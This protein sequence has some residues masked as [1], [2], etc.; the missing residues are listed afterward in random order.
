MDLV[1]DNKI[2][3]V[4]RLREYN[5][6]ISEFTSKFNDIPELYKTYPTFYIDYTELENNQFNNCLPISLN[7]IIYVT[8]TLSFKELLMNLID[9]RTDYIYKYM[10]PIIEKFIYH[11]KNSMIFN[12]PVD[13]IALLLT[14]YYDKIKYPMDLGTIRNNLHNGYYKDINSIFFDIMKTFDNAMIY[15]HTQHYVHQIAKTLLTEFNIDKNSIIDKINRELDKKSNHH[16]CKYCHIPESSCQLCGAKC[17]KLEPPTLICYGTCNQRIKRN[18]V[19]YVTID[20]I[21]SWCLRC[22]SALPH[23]VIENKP[24]KISLFKNN[25]LKR[26][27]DE[28]INESWIKC[29][30]CNQWVHQVCALYNDLAKLEQLNLTNKHDNIS[31][32]CPF[33]ILDKA[34]SINK[35]KLSNNKRKISELKPDSKQKIVK[36]NTGVNNDIR[37]YFFKKKNDKVKINEDNIIIEQSNI[38]TNIVSN[39]D[40]QKLKF[41]DKDNIK[42]AKDQ[43][44]AKSLPRTKLSDFLEKIIGD[45]LNELGFDNVMETVTIRLTSNTSQ[46][47]E[48][49][50]HVILNLMTKD[51]NSVP[52]FLPY[53]QKCILMFQSIN[54][55]DVCLFC[56]YVQEFDKNCPPPN[57]SVVYISYLDS[58][59]YFRPMEA[60][61]IVY[62]EILIG[63]L[64]WIQMRG[65]KQAHIWSCPPQRGDNFI[66]W[67][68]PTQ[69]KTPSRDRL[70]GWYKSMLFR[71]SLLGII[72][73][74]STLWDVYFAKYEKQEKKE[75]LIRQQRSTSISPSSTEKIKNNKINSNNSINNKPE[76]V[77]K[78]TKFYKMQHSQ[79]NYI[80]KQDTESS[81]N[82]P[83]IQNDLVPISPPIFEGDYWVNECLR[84]TKLY[85]NRDQ[86]LIE[87][88]GSNLAKNQKKVREILKIMLLNPLLKDFRN[89]VDIVL[90][91]IPNYFEII[92]KPMDINT[93]RSKLNNNSY[94]T[95]CDFAND[96][97]LIFNNSITFNSPTHILHELSRKE[98]EKFEKMLYLIIQEF[99]GFDVIANT[100]SL[101][102]NFLQSYPLY[103]Q[104]YNISPSMETNSSSLLIEE[105]F[106]N[107]NNIGKSLDNDF[108]DD[109]LD[110]CNEELD[111]NNNSITEIDNENEDDEDDVDISILPN[112]QRVT[113]NASTIS[114]ISTSS[115]NIW[116][117]RP[118]RSLSCGVLPIN[119]DNTNEHTILEYNSNQNQFNN[120][121]KGKEFIPD[122]INIPFKNPELG[123][124]G[125]FSM[126]NDL[127]KGVNHLKDDLFVITFANPNDENSYFSSSSLTDTEA[128]VFLDENKIKSTSNNLLSESIINTDNIKSLPSEDNELIN[129]N[130]NVY[131]R[132]YRNSSQRQHLPFIALFRGK[133]KGKILSAHNSYQEN[134]NDLTLSDSC[135]SYLSNL[136]SD[137]SDPDGK[138]HSPILDFRHTLLETFQYKHYQFDTLRRAKHSSLMLLYYLQHPYSDHVRVSC[139][140][141]KNLIKGGTRWHCIECSDFDVCPTCN[142]NSKH[143]HIL[144]PFRLTFI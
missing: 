103:I 101:I 78:R 28:E 12:N 3:N 84:L 72:G 29:D 65:F 92:S 91:E 60:R 18:T 8:N 44:K 134:E 75:M 102:D 54:G 108:Q 135:L 66:F 109:K 77:D 98:L 110:I 133:G 50:K 114:N 70:N 90:L 73:D 52:K 83:I 53:N 20:G 144:S 94:F 112:L 55:I 139:S 74:A 93:V 120:K 136:K 26:R 13:P 21:M 63:Y 113:S 87:H 41:A 138:F 22:Y 128:K 89:P 126:M 106:I 1:I 9:L 140:V 79:S 95:I 31:F 45:R 119:R 125:V 64:K 88:N 76:K 36:V 61:T 46:L 2:R 56:L 129:Q 86:G 33:C 141:C 38:E 7:K 71:A 43:F 24:P 30:Y 107:N 59:D 49:P 81:I 82:S 42:I 131:S 17:L 57:K 15:N 137:T 25:L 124:N 11:P 80:V 142:K 97:R 39:N 123:F 68:H 19:Y 115:S 100:K 14:D 6:K 23:V 4:D 143:I 96:I 35:Q 51:G 37:N 16:K 34:S 62:H 47:L 40:N 122:P 127:S 130:L 99:H 85:R 121:N 111:T 132:R 118:L 104:Q 67:C 27:A 5:D 32:T 116:D 117:R 105:N 69:Q 58:V 10:R 48:V